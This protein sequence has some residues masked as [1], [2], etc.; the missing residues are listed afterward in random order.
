M[1]MSREAFSALPGSTFHVLYPGTVSQPLCKV[2]QFHSAVKDHTFIDTWQP[3]NAAEADGG[4]DIGDW[5]SWTCC[6]R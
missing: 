2:G 5:T 6:A 1:F 3:S 4:M